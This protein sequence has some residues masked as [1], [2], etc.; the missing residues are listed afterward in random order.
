MWTLA[1]YSY[2]PQTL[3]DVSCFFSFVLFFF[4]Q[5]HCWQ[6][7]FAKSALVYLSLS[8]VADIKKVNLRKIMAIKKCSEAVI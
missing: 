1:M 2:M 4:H 8:E 6:T 7:T 5:V 3:R